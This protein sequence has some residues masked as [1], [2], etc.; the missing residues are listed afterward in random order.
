[1]GVLHGRLGVMQT[2]AIERLARSDMGRH[3][4]G[5][6]L[7]GVKLPAG[8]RRGPST[9]PGENSLVSSWICAVENKLDRQG[10]KTGRR[11]GIGRMHER[12]GDGSC[13][14]R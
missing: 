5:A 14:V 2:G 4:R 10:E 9:A 6:L 8:D 13:R 11:Y 7:V 3:R 1:M 12:E